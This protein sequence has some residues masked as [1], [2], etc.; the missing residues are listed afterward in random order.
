[1]QH[2]DKLISFLKSIEKSIGEDL[3]EKL[4]SQDS[5][6]GVMYDLSKIH[7]PLINGF[8]KLR[9]ILSA[10][11]TV[12]TKWAKNFVSLLWYLIFN[13]SLKGSFEFANIIWIF[14]QG[15]FLYQASLDVDSLFTNL[16]LDETSNVYVNELFKNN[17]S[18]HCLNKKRI[19]DMLSLLTKE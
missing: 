10:L 4:C 9:P 5:Q 3:H 2:E 17:K 16:P 15:A 13:E 11:N 1:M 7:K 18:V 8:P 19:S 6:L 12:T 14:S